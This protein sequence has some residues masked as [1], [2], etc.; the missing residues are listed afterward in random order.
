MKRFLLIPM[1]AGLFC[2]ACS[3]KYDDSALNGRVDQ[4]QERIERLEELCRQ[5]NTNISSLQSL[6]TAL[7]KDD[8]IVAVT[9]IIKEGATVG[10]TI[11]FKYGGP[12]TIYHGIDGKDGSTPVIVVAQHEGITTGPL[13]VHG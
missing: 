5:M 7:E 1:L 8:R 12:L 11:T 10:Y 4:L 13:T 6:V 2:A 9:P 3:D